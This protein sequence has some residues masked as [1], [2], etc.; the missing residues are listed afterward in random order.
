M[1]ILNYTTKVAATRTASE[2]QELLARKGAQRVSVDYDSQ[3][4]PA[5]IEFMFHV[6]KQPVWFRLPCNV[7]GVFKAMSRDGSGV[8]R[9]LQSKAQGQRAAWR[10]VKNWVEVQL[11][12]IEANQMEM[13]EVFLPYSIDREG[14]TM[15]ARF[16]ESQQKQLETGDGQ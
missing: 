2:I 14:H 8:P 13:A 1:A 12:M 5:A 16:K 6:H 3:G 4:D 9:K 15:Y 10:I 11:A 7:D